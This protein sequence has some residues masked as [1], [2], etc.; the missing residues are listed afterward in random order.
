MQW[1]WTWGGT[2]FGYR[3]GGNLWTHDGRNVGR[4]Y[5]DEVYGPDGSYLGELRNKNRLITHTSKKH[6]RKPSFSPLSRRVGYV[7]YVDYVGYVMYVGYE[8]FPGPKKF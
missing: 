7:P 3:D 1:L 5:E 8:D 2:S 4:F 6:R